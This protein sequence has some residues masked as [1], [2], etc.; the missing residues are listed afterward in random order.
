LRELYTEEW[1]VLTLT[2]LGKLVE[3]SRKYNPFGNTY[4]EHNNLWPIPFSEIEKN[5][6]AELEQNPGY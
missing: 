1:R 6:E 2:R 4:A 5:I 3:R